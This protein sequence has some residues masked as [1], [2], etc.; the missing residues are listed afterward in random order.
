MDQFGYAIE[1][2][3]ALSL[4][5]LLYILN[6]YIQGTRGLFILRDDNEL[7]RVQNKKGKV[8]SHISLTACAE[9]ALKYEEVKE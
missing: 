2:A 7:W 6:T 8:F 3:D 5:E 1:S 4:R 9:F